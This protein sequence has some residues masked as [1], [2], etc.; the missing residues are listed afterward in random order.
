[1]Y[2]KIS[3]YPLKELSNLW[4]ICIINLYC[5][6]LV[7]TNVFIHTYVSINKKCIQISQYTYIHIKKDKLYINIFISNLY[8]NTQNSNY[9]KYFYTYI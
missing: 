5:N 1:M 4:N 6:M 7:E 8:Q 9:D 3:M 2:V